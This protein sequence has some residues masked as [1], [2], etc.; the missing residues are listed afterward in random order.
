MGYYNM[1]MENLEL[2]I[3]FPVMEELSE[4]GEVQ[5]GFIPGG[6]YAVCMHVGPYDAIEPAYDALNTWVLEQGHTP[7]G[8]AYEHYLNDPAST[9]EDELQTQVAFL[10]QEE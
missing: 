9:P 5:A 3:G 6:R 2:E 4:D 10:L 1:D 7:A 8:I